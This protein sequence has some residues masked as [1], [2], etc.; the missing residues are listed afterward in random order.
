MSVRR[1][2]SFKPGSQF[3]ETRITATDP[4]H[5]LSTR[6]VRKRAKPTGFMRRVS[7]AFHD[8]SKWRALLSPGKVQVLQKTKGRRSLDMAPGPL[9]NL[10]SEGSAKTATA[11]QVGESP[12]KAQPKN[13]K[14]NRRGTIVNVL[15][16]ASFDSTVEKGHK[17]EDVVSYRGVLLTGALGAVITHAVRVLVIRAG[18]EYLIG[19][20]DPSTRKRMKSKFALPPTA[21]SFL[22]GNKG[23]TLEL[24]ILSLL[25]SMTWVAFG[26]YKLIKSKWND[27]TGSTRLLAGSAGFY[28][29]TLFSVK[30]SLEQS[31]NRNLSLAESKTHSNIVRTRPSRTRLTVYLD[32]SKPPFPHLDRADS[33]R[34]DSSF[35]RCGLA[36]SLH[37]G[38][39]HG[40]RDLLD[41]SIYFRVSPRAEREHCTQGRW[42]SRCSIRGIHKRDR[43][44]SICREA[45]GKTP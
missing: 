43:T 34:L 44:S 42:C 6:R 18:K 5:F 40:A 1:R 31:K 4:A 9:A 22:R 35:R 36:R 10:L 26:L 45:F 7:R 37:D 29:Y 32:P 17:N 19:L 27:R 24:Y 23:R 2:D 41:C 38:S 15:R 3:E 12:T 21:L 14:R 39:T 16:S 33:N 30:V 13:P 20:L 25:H 11:V 28:L 8:D